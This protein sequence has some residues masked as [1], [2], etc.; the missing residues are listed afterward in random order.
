MQY[1]LIIS[2][3]KAKVWDF[4]GEVAGMA[5]IVIDKEIL[6]QVYLNI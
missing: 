1:N 5:K 6:E 2:T 3:S 4:K